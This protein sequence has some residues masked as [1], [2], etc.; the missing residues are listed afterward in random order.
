M[1]GS[2]DHSPRSVQAVIDDSTLGERHWLDVKE[3]A[4]SGY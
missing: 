1:Y 2:A 3:F 4:V